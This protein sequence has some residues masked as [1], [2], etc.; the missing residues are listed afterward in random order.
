MFG[1][2]TF[3]MLSE[4]MIFNKTVYIFYENNTWMIRPLPI[5]KLLII[6]KA[7]HFKYIFCMTSI[8]LTRRGNMFPS[9]H[10]LYQIINIHIYA[11]IYIYIY[12]RMSRK[13]RMMFIVH[14]KTNSS[15]WNTGIRALQ[16]S[17]TTVIFLSHAAIFKAEC[18]H[19]T[20]WTVLGPLY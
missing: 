14:A 13:L 19:V 3:S 11:Y 6:L 2:L 12:L 7:R 18:W 9:I 20:C 16:F 10:I 15:F 17:F 5:I 8:T 1:E 4:T